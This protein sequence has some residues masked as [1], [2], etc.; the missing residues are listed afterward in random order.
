MNPR[1]AVLLAVMAGLVA[2]EQAK[3]QAK[4]TTNGVLV[5]R[6]G[7]PL[8]KATVVLGAVSGDEETTYA[9]VKLGLATAVTDDSG[10]F[11]LSGIAPGR[12]TIVYYPPGPAPAKPPAEMS[13][14]GLAAGIKSFLPMMRDV[15]VGRMGTPYPDRVWAREFTLL[16]GHT[17]WCIGLGEPL[18]KVWNATARRGAQ[19]PYLEVRRGV[20]WQEKFDD[21]G[22][23]KLEAWSF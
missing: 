13:I 22:Q 8:A 20:V 14:K 7:K 1:V 10:R 4:A 11:Q 5:G 21:K 3:A 6:S 18:M 17:L 16:K 12:Y 15:E 19:G 2:A 23:V 9:K